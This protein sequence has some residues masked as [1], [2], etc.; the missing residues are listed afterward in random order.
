MISNLASE[1]NEDS[2][3]SCESV[4]GQVWF[5]QHCS[6][7]SLQ[8]YRKD[9]KFSDRYVWANSADTDQTAPRSSPI[10]VYTI[11]HSVC[12]VWTHYSIVE[13]H[14]SNLRVITTI[15]W[16]FEYLGNLWYHIFDY[17]RNEPIDSNIHY[18]EVTFCLQHTLLFYYIVSCFVSV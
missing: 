14:S 10:R 12:I 8:W 11:C 2:N 9:P 1:I 13:P 7:L 18:G 4:H 16:V 17:T 5:M 3:I 6:R 15:V